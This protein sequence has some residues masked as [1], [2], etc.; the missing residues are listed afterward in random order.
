MRIYVSI[1]PNCANCENFCNY[2]EHLE[3]E[4]EIELKCC[5]KYTNSGNNEKS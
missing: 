1:E 4:I 3:S 2:I 5:K